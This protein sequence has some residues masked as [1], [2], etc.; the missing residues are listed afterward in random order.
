MT[1]EKTKLE[2]LQAALNLILEEIGNVT[3]GEAIGWTE[4]KLNA[5]A[6]RQE[7]HEDEKQQ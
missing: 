4:M 6:L 2:R 3:V 7:G 1:E 5:I